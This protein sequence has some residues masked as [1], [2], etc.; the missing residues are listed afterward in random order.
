MRRFRDHAGGT[1]EAG[2]TDSALAGID[3]DDNPQHWIE[4]SKRRC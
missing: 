2:L 1:G 4:Q 3:T